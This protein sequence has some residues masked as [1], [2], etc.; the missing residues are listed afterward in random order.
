MHDAEVK[1]HFAALLVALIRA[2][3]FDA[4]AALRDWATEWLYNDVDDDVEHLEEELGID[5]YDD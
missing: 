1:V 2:R 5:G 4:A 3:Q